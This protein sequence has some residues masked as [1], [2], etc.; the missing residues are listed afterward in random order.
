[1]KGVMHVSDAAEL[2][3]AIEQQVRH[4]VASGKISGMPMITLAEG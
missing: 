4:I 3:S 1:M 2:Q